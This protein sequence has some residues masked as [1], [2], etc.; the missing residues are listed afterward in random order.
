LTIDQRAHF[1]TLQRF[2]E[3]KRAFF[4]GDLTTARAALTE[5]N[6]SMRSLKLGVVLLALRAAPGL[7]SLAYDVRDRVVFRGART[8]Y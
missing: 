2:H 1:A 3:G 6:R 7:V 4:R 5:A 8:K